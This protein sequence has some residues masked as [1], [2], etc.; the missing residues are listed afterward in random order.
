MGHK[1]ASEASR[2]ILL[3]NIHEGVLINSKLM[4]FLDFVGDQVYNCLQ[5][6]V[7]VLIMSVL[8]FLSND[9]DQGRR[10]FIFYSNIEF[11]KKL[12]H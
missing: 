7:L 4:C 8:L 1:S 2:K 5:C 6:L 12:D 3:I 10:V 9:K 11:K